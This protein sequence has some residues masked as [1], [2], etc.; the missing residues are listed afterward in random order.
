[1]PEE[2]GTDDVSD[3]DDI[4]LGSLRQLPDRQVLLSYNPDLTYIPLVKT[5]PRP[6]E[7]YLVIRNTYIVIRNA[8]TMI[9]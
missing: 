8:V 3:D 4:V 5:T 7:P 6:L 1:M 2:S 9:G